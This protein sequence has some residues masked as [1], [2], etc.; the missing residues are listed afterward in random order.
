MNNGTGRIENTGER[1]IVTPI[2]C[3]HCVSV[4][5]CAERMQNYIF[6]SANKIE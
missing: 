2:N 4:C 1:E 6:I 3:L 5:M